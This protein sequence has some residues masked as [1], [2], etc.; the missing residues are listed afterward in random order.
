M[1][2]PDWTHLYFNNFPKNVIELLE[3]YYHDYGIGKGINRENYITWNPAAQAV[4]YPF[5]IRDK[6][7][8]IKGINFYPFYFVSYPNSG[9]SPIHIDRLRTF[10]LNIPIKVDHNRS[11]TLV[12]D[13]HFFEKYGE[14]SI[15]IEEG[16]EHY[17]W[18][19]ALESDM[20]SVDLDRP[21]LLNVSKPHGWTNYSNDIRVIAS[22]GLVDPILSL[23]QVY[24]A[25]RIFI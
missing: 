9:K 7:I 14:P 12:D 17:L 16:I 24:S 18:P 25:L 8:K 6:T 22:L 15:E 5:F 19:E 20:L 23:E 2:D 4:S 13:G 21:M 3:K 10:G 11:K 1:I